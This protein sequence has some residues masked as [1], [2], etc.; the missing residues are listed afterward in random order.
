MILCIKILT[1]QPTFHLGKIVETW[2]SKDG[3]LLCVCINQSSPSEFSGHHSRKIQMWE[4][5]NS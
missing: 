4:A 5:N 3:A 2:G 1:V